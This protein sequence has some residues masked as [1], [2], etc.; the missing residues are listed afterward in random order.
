MITRFINW[1]FPARQL[2]AQLALAQQQA[3]AANEKLAATAAALTQAVNERE[4][5][6]DQCKRY[7]NTVENLSETNKSLRRDFDDKV[8]ELADAHEQLMRRQRPAL[9]ARTGGLTDEQIAEILAGK[10]TLFEVKAILQVIDE[11]AVQAMEESAIP[12]SANYTEE[13]RT[14][15]A[16]GTCALVN[17]KSRVEELVRTAAR[18]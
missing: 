6:C 15:S 11:C 14:Y 5:Y 12:P 4:H 17:L 10:H 16:G 18:N 2:R 8:Q 3:F 9:F 1:L 7:L 13:Q